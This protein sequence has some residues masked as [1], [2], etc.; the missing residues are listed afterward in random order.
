MLYIKVDLYNF[1]KYFQRVRNF[2][3]FQ[4]YVL[5]LQQADSR[6]MGKTHGCWHFAWW[7]DTR[8][9]VSANVETTLSAGVS[10]HAVQS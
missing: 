1:P 2:W 7:C 6:E 4:H 3:Q 10:V 8:F 9:M 5:F